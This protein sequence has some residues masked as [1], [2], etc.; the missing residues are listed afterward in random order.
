LLDNG[1]VS[2][3]PEGFI[4]SYVAEDN[5]PANPLSLDLVVSLGRNTELY[6]P[7][8][9]I[10]LV[11]GMSGQEP[12][13]QIQ[14]S[15]ASQTFSLTGKVNLRSGY[16][17][18]LL[19]NFFIRE[20]TIEFAENQLKFDPLITAVAEARE[21]GRE[22]MIL[23]TLAADRQSFN[24]FNPRLSS[25]PPMNE[26]ELLALLG[27]GLAMIKDTGTTD[28]LSV[29]EAVIASSEFLLQNALF[30]SFEQRVQK[31]LGLD[32]VYLRSS[33]L[34]KWLLDITAQQP[35]GG[36]SLSDYLS[37][38][39]FYAGK[40]ITESAFAHFIVRM[41]EN[42]LEESGSL[43]LDSELGIEFNSPF[44]LLLWSMSS[45]GEGT[46]LNNQKLSLSWR[47]RY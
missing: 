41:S 35:S 21:P 14:Y 4:I 17:L 19:R 25:I 10:P 34:Q 11:R 22:G 45:G 43:Q 27:G 18:Y 3:N 16:V 44:G 13:L 8:E 29:R 2:V 26:A 30:R 1:K 5:Q 42:P 9:D 46:P 12:Q 6:L 32:V 33:F 40:Y 47:I 37:G 38:T 15:E 31:A 23:V 7:S 36:I 28:P 24:N 39:E 20:C